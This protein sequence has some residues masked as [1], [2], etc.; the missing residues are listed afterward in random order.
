M[1]TVQC[2]NMLPVDSVSDVAVSVS[3]SA[4]LQL[5]MVSG[6]LKTRRPHTRRA[7]AHSSAVCEADQYFIER[8]YCISIKVSFMYAFEPA[9]DDEQLGAM[10]AIIYFDEQQD[11]KQC[12]DSK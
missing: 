5:G 10:R 7:T 11:H 2:G 8:L 3:S 9:S 6:S 1:S 4:R 12:I